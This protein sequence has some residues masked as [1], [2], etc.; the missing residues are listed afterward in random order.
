MQNIHGDEVK[1]G[2]DRMGS[3]NHRKYN[4]GWHNLLCGIFGTMDTYEIRTALGK[5]DS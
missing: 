3:S 1:L 5:E 2:F 4:S